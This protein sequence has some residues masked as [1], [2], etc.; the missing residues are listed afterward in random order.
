MKS[1]VDLIN[2]RKT[3]IFKN[4]PLWKLEKMLTQ[5]GITVSERDKENRELLVFWCEQGFE[6]YVKEFSVMDGKRYDSEA[7][8]RELHQRWG[9]KNGCFT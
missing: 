6:S 4:A 7:Y 2:E 5:R 3:W 8:I 1:D 9:F